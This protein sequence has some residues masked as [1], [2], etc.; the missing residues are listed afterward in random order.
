VGFQHVEQSLPVLVN[1]DIRPR[2]V[3]G[4]GRSDLDREHA[5]GSQALQNRVVEVVV[6]VEELG[7][8]GSILGV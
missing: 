5:V 4:G 6:G 1:P 2:I 8:V 3:N 7:N